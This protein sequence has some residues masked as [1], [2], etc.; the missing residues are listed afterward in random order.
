[1]DIEIA[2]RLPSA[3]MDAV[4]VVTVRHLDDLKPHTEAWDRLAWE[5]PQGLATM[6]PAWV[7][8]TFQHGLWPH[9]RWMC[10]FAYAG[11]RL[12]GVMPVVIMPHPIL[13]HRRPLLRT[14]GKL[15]PSG[16]IALASDCATEAFAA[17]LAEV[18]R[19]EPSHVGLDLQAVRKNSPVWSALQNGAARHIACTSARHGFSILDVSGSFDSFIGNLKKMASNL[20]RFH[21]KIKK[22]GKVRF[23]IVD[24]RHARADFLSQFAALEAAGWKGRCGGAILN[25]PDSFA[26]H[27]ALVENFAAQG[28]LMWHR[29]W[30]DDTLVGA[31]IALRCNR[32]LMLPKYTFNED[33]AECRVGT[34]LTE[35]TIRDG[36]ARPE[37][38]EIN[39]MSKAQAHSYWHMP[40]EEYIDLHLVRRSAMPMLIHLPG[41][42]LR[43]A[44]WTHIRSRVPESV[45]ELYRRYRRRGG[46][47]PRRAAEAH[48]I[49]QGNII[50]K[51]M[52]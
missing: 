29:I 46:R 17:L 14:Y 8:A 31:Q 19:Q 26:F 10:C 4:R 16:D 1:M 42:W 12:V 6:L 28:R 25:N 35:A 3:A 47:K 27:A 39:P 22:R 23:E 5:A 41:I 43:K 37:L 7:K 50:H 15:T 49:P 48:F 21:R 34:L 20:G 9:W 18:V 40:E 38:D 13:G 2:Y 24:G 52:S 44:Y 45:R 33:F 36:F 32:S 30:V 11:Q 51:R